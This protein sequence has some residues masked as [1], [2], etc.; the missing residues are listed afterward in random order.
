MLFL[1]LF[2]WQLWHRFHKRKVAQKGAASM[3]MKRALCC[4]GMLCSYFSTWHAEIK[5]ADFLSGWEKKPEGMWACKHEIISPSPLPPLT[6]LAFLRSISSLDLGISI[7][8]QTSDIVW[9]P[10]WSF[11][12]CSLKLFLAFAQQIAIPGSQFCWASW[13]LTACLQLGAV[14]LR[15][16][17]Q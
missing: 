6:P 5:T 8:Q 2:E 16:W 13:A 1:R 11:L 14:L 7:V 17:G 9:E 12:L 3:S 10:L 15:D 4:T